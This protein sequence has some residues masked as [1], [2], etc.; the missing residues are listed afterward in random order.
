MLMNEPAPQ[1][2]GHT[3]AG[4]AVVEAKSDCALCV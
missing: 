4:A 3:F 1:K 2:V